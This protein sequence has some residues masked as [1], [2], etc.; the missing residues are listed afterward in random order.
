VSEAG[1]GPGGAL[2]AGENPTDVPA[3]AFNPFNPFNQI[4][5][6]GSRARLAEFGNRIEDDTTQAYVTTLGVKGDRLLDGNWG[7]DAGLRYSEIENDRSRQQVSASRFNR[8]LNA[9]DPIFDPASDQFIGTTTPYNPFGD[10]RV[11]ITSNIPSINFATVH[12]KELDVS[13]LT[14][15]N[16]QIYNTELF[17]LPAG[18]VGLAFGAEFR[19]ESIEQDPDQLELEHDIIAPSPRLSILP[20]AGRK[21]YA[22]FGETRV[23]LFSPEMGVIG[24]HSLEL[25]AGLRFEEFLSN[26][27][28]VLV[29][30]VGVRWAPLDEQL[31]IHS[32]WTEGF[33]EPSLFQLYG[34][35]ALGVIP[36]RF[37]NIPEPET[38]FAIGSNPNLKPEDSRTWTGGA[39][40]TPKWLPWG[41][42][43]LW[44]DLWDIERTG[45]IG[46]P[47]AQELVRRV[48]NG[49]TLLPGEDVQIDPATGAIEFIRTG[50]QNTG[51]QSARG[52]DFAALYQFMAPFGL[53]TVSGEWAYLDQFV[54]Q[55]S[56]GSFGR[57]RVGQAAD[58]FSNE[59]WYRWKGNTRIDWTWHNFD[60][61]ASWRYVGGFREIIK[62]SLVNSPGF[63]NGV[64]EHWTNPTNFIDAQ[65]SYSL[66]FTP[67]QENDP[68]AGYS[69]AAREAIKSKDGKA[70]EST[71]AYSIGCWKTIIN[72]S[73][74][75]IGCNNIFGQDPP[76]AFGFFFGNGINYPGFSYD[77]IGR[78][79]YVELTKKF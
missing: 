73:T 62:N 9:A 25:T 41:A 39:A 43:T 45:T 48:L 64:H 5:S 36:F 78:F 13:K 26:D 35:P 72:N 18:G 52:A 28:N 75:T 27:S 47:S 34:L 69:N 32:S 3:D 77:N 14:E 19:R 70:V 22:V 17:K 68:V 38:V 51:R 49:R 33:S 46:T 63:P 23:P 29:P 59:G 21:D 56:A 15:V 30:K 42:M 53:V 1:S 8:I 7:Y 57:D 61:N 6:G 40:Y 10:Y 11:P 79:W 65:A 60:L 37:H 31:T 58:Q 24:L 54:L 12:S 50:F 66:I 44:L 2:S 74:I 76:R 55:Q 4:I 20:Q 71:A 16:L 67:P